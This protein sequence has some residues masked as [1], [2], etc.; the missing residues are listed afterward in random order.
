MQL[1]MENGNIEIIK[2]LLSK[3]EIKITSK[4]LLNYIN[5]LTNQK[6]FHF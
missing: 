1:K 6:F 3:E 4:K 5:V 2:L